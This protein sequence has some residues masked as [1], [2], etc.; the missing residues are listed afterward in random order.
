MQVFLPSQI[1]LGPQKFCFGFCNRMPKE[2][3]VGM[4]V[5]NFPYVKGVWSSSIVV[6]WS[7]QI[8]CKN[9]VGNDGMYE[10]E[11]C[12]VMNAKVCSCLMLH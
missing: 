2:Y 11:C 10:H 6:V 8:R 12:M 4:I 9:F 5:V 3:G 1:H 7:E